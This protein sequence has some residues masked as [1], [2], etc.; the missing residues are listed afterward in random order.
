[1]G[2]AKSQKIFDERK[3]LVFIILSSIF[4]AS[5]TM[6]NVLGTSRFVDLSCVFFWG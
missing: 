4:I 1:M 3:S 5:M 2:S 6:L